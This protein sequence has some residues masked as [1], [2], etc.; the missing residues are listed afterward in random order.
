MRGVALRILF[1][2]AIGAF[3]DAML[4]I[5]GATSPLHWLWAPVFGAAV[6]T[7]IG[8][9]VLRIFRVEIASGWLHASFV[10]G[11]SLVTVTAIG[12]A[13]LWQWSAQTA[14]LLWGAVA[15]TG[16]AFGGFL[17]GRAPRLDAADPVAAL[18]MAA[19]AGYFARHLAAS[20]PILEQT[21]T[22]PAWIDYFQHGMTIA[23]FGDPLTLGSGNDA[24]AGAFRPFYHVAPF[25]PAA[26][27][28]GITGLPGVGLATAVLAPLGLLVGLCGLY[29][30]GI[31][32]AGPAWSLVAVLLVALLPDASHYGLRNDFFGF[33]WL[34][35]INPG[36]PYAVGLSAV[37][38]LVS[39]HW[40]RAG[41]AALLWLVALLIAMLILVH[42]H[43]FT[44][45]APAVAATIALARIPP[46]WRG[47]ALA[48]STALGTVATLAMI[49]GFIGNYAQV[50]RPTDFVAAALNNGPSDYLRF[51][52]M[53]IH[54]GPAMRTLATFGGGLAVMVAAL[55]VWIAIFPAAAW[56]EARRDRFRPEDYFPLVLS[57][58]YIAQ[59]FWA[60]VA[61]YY[62]DVTEFRHRQFLLVYAIVLLWTIPRLAV[63]AGLG[64]LIGRVP[65]PRALAAGAILALAAV[66]I[67]GD[68]NPAVPSPIMTWARHYNDPPLDP[69]MPQAAAWLRARA[70][71]GDVMALPV[72]ESRTLLFGQANEMGGLT[73]IPVY[74]ARIDINLVAHGAAIAALTRRREA[75]IAAVERISDRN[76]ALAALRGLGVKW[77]VAV[78]ADLPAWDRTGDAATFHAGSTFVYDSGLTQSPSRSEDAR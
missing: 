46:P 9:I 14:F 3:V 6:A 57:L 52:G 16:V 22:F 4:L 64:E 2:G 47:R 38:W 8:E 63:I 29:A 19:V 12:P 51:Y 78:T 60:P 20:L 71:P 61:P 34:V 76:A 45:M 26:A 77:F 27:L 68:V 41:R 56:W 55:G 36:A 40:F 42:I 23:E 73:G 15:L 70:R 18:I 13:L 39:L 72:A 28:A 43:M 5:G 53:L 10:T 67:Y 58:A 74:A 65:A 62:N 35:F 33:Q 75:A 66:A 17:P 24:L 50:A 25:Q 30:L 49:A 48:A 11:L 7:G 21:G 69:G 1:Y 59:I 31:E 37:A 44:L 54:E 32:F